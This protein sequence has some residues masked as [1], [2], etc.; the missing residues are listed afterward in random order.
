M[1]DLERLKHLLIAD[2]RE[3]LS[4]VERR[5]EAL[6]QVN[7]ELASQLP[8]LVR[9]APVEPMNRALANPVAAAL[10]SAVQRNRTSIVD[11]LFP[12]IGPIIRKAIAE[13]LRGLMRDMNRVLESTFTPRGIRWRIEAWSSGLPYAHVVLKHT[14]RYQIDHVF[15]IERDSGLVLHRVS[16]P[17]LPDLDADA[18]AGMLTAIGQFVRDSVSGDGDNSLEAARV[19]EHLLWIVEGPRASLACFI[20]GVPPDELRSV[21]SDRLEQI[22]ADMLG[23]DVDPEDAMETVARS[24][25]L[26]ASLEP[27]SLVAASAS[28]VEQES[29]ARKRSVRW[30]WLLVLLVLLAVL[31]WHFLRVERWNEQVLQLRAQLEKHPGFQLSTLD[32]EPWEKLTVR[33]LLDADAEPLAPVLDAAGLDGIRP[34]IQVRGFVSTDD[35]VVAKRARRMLDAPHGVQVD[36]KDGVLT[37]RGDAELEW[38]TREK[39]R[40][41]LIAGVR[42]VDW[43]VR[44]HDPRTAA[45]AAARAELQEISARLDKTRVIFL[46]DSEADADAAASLGVMASALSRAHALATNSG[47]PFALHVF[48][49]TDTPGTDQINL[50]LRV[51]RAAWLRDKL[52]E[53]GVDEKLLEGAVMDS[54]A[55]GKDSEFRGAGV[56]IEF[57]DATQ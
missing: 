15:L 24:A 6:E 28:M 53:S 4:R 26:D 13:A 27:M 39:P 36:V 55:S 45:L 2:E 56:R 10:G 41:S 25:D 34:E 3:V 44:G 14:L 52:R 50:D 19:G 48:G 23:A 43:Q 46:R 17:G 57:A 31:G 21:L 38:V 42:Q 12:V 51:A 16:S 47:I 30:P 7:A 20:Q 1:G 33:G 18:I 5:V 9:A 11:A 54:G 32:S 29:P 40:A 37:V 8:S 22:H 49:Y 35:T